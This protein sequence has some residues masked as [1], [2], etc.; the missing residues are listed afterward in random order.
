M[1]NIDKNTWIVLFGVVAIL[2]IFLFSNKHKDEDVDLVPDVEV[3]DV[4]EVKDTPKKSVTKK[5][6]PP[7]PTMSY[8]EALETYKDRRIQIDSMC[9]AIPNQVTYKN[10]ISIMLD[11]RS[12]TT[13]NINLGGAMTI[14]PYDYKIVK[15]STQ[16]LPATWYLDCDNRENVATILIQQ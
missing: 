15:L 3:G 11:N 4:P 12:D 6:I 9:E 5:P 8:L 2:S 7:A 10:G 16:T 13:K 1:K 14:K